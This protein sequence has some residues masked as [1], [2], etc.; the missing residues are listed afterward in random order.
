MTPD[1][2]GLFATSKRTLR[3][4]VVAV[5]LSGAFV[6]LLKAAS[7]FAAASML[8]PDATGSWLAV[9]GGLL[10]GGFK[11]R[12]LFSVFCRRNLD[13]I[14]RLNEPRLWQA[15]RPGFY[16][17]L[18]AMIIL[19]AGLSKWALGNYVA[20]IALVTLDIS[21]G[22]ALLGSSLTFWQRPPDS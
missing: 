17:F 19:G 18:A 14:A 12:Y 13:R 21:L 6:L 4:I 8:K 1:R 5:W 7:L 15:F 9:P 2:T 20:L 10:I 22:I 3:A 11:A 16:V